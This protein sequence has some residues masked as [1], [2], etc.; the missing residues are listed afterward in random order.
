[1]LWDHARNG[2]KTVQQGSDFV[3]SPLVGCGQQWHGARRA[4]CRLG[5]AAAGAAYSS[6]VTVAP[7]RLSRTQLFGGTGCQG[8]VE[9]SSGS[10]AMT[11]PR[12]PSLT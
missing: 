11:L 6:A 2:P 9:G 7:S 1:V 4:S 5:H 12:S 10:E 3:R 8:P